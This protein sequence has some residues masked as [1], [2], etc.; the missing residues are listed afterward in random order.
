MSTSPVVPYEMRT[1][2]LE[3]RAFTESDVATLVELYADPE[4]ARYIGGDRLTPD[5]VDAQAATFASVWW[6]HGYGQSMLVERSTRNVIG[7]VGLHPWPRWDELELGWVLARRS[8][9]QGL[10]REAAGVW[11]DWADATRP[12]SYLTAV[13]DP[14]NAPSIRLAERLGFTFDRSDETAWSSVVVYRY[15]L[16]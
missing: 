9:R 8:Q 12:A 6:S 1:E 2:R 4:V 7:R 3:L 16:S 13:I 14:R 5:V 11:L 10:A 15:D